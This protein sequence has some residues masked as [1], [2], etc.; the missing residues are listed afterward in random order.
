[1]G[2][3]A[4]GLELSSLDGIAVHEA[5]G[6][7]HHAL[8]VHIAGEGGAPR[9]FSIGRDRDRLCRYCVHDLLSPRDR[10]CVADFRGLQALR[11][12]LEETRGAKGPAAITKRRELYK[13]RA[14]AHRMR[15]HSDQMAARREVFLVQLDAREQELARVDQETRDVVS[16]ACARS[17]VVGEVQRGGG[18]ALEGIALPR[19]AAVT[20]A[21]RCLYKLA[22][23]PVGERG[24]PQFAHDLE[25]ELDRRFGIVGATA[26]VG[27]IVA[28]CIERQ[29]QVL[30][31][32]DPVITCW[33]E[34]GIVLSDLERSVGAAWALASDAERS[35]HVGV[36]PRYALFVLMRR[37][38][39]GAVQRAPRHVVT[40][41]GGLAPHEAEML[42]ALWDPFGAGP[43]RSAHVALAAVRRLGES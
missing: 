41:S 9:P 17:L 13:L 24:G 23:G 21:L 26:Q 10:E 28:W 27:Q 16:A 5:G 18:A 29:R 35:C 25:V 4:E 11:R 12:R 42:L 33:H 1:M 3:L 8:C 6:L 43:Y 7:V 39:H 15:P 34:R 32:D 36:Y 22:Q 14:L 2:A 37:H 30:A 20:L 38:H 31:G 40:L 19:Q